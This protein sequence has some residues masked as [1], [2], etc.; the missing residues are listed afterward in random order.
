MKLIDALFA[1]IAPRA[2]EKNIVTYGEYRITVLTD[3]LFR[4]EYGSASF[5]DEATQAVWFRDLPPVGFSVSREGEALHIVTAACTLCVRP[6]PQDCTVLLDGCE[7]ALD[8]AGNLLGTTR[9]LDMNRKGKVLVNGRRV[10]FSD[11]A[12]LEAGVV[13][14]TGVA[15]LDD[16]STPLLGADGLTHPR[17]AVGIDRYIFAYGHDYRAAVRALFALC[18]PAP[19]LPRYAFGNW[20][21]RYHAYTD[22]EYLQ[23]TD[24]FER[25]RV[26]LSVATV[27]MD[28]HY[29]DIGAEFGKEAEVPARSYGNRVSGW[30]GF[31]WNR[32]LFPDHRAFLRELHARGLRVT[33]NLHPAD[34]VRWFED[35][36]RPM[37]AATG[38]DPQSRAPVAFD[39]SDPAFINAYFGVLLQGLQEDGVDFWWIDWQQEKVRRG[40]NG[41]FDPLWT[42]NHYHYLYSARGG[43]R[44]MTLSRYAGIGSHRYPL[45]FSG[46]TVVTWELLEF[47]PYFTATAA[48]AGYF[49]WSHDIGG[50]HFGIKDDELY[51]RWLQFAVYNPVLR[52]HSS[53]MALTGKEP[54]KFS[55]GTAAIAE[56]LLRRREALVPYLYTL[57]ARAHFLGRA[58]AEPMYYEYPASPQA[59][60]A[61]GQY[62]FGELMVAPVTQRTDAQTGLAK[63]RV[64]LPEGEWLD[65]STRLIYRGGRTVTLWRYL[66]ETPVFMRRGSLFVAGDGQGLAMTAFGE[67]G[68]F[69]LYED[70]GETR[71]FEQGVYNITQFTLR[72]EGEETVLYILPGEHPELLPAT[73]SL[74]LTFEGIASADVAAE[75]EGKKLS[76]RLT[77]GE[78]TEVFVPAYDPAAVVCVRLKNLVPVTRRRA[79]ERRTEQLFTRLNGDNGQI[80]AWYRAV[81]QDPPRQKSRLF[82]LGLPAALAEALWE[83]R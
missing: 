62:W 68:T 70:D 50:H 17:G 33:L 15:V 55:P 78:R 14:Q 38:V 77:G 47:M 36:Y 73:R 44:G 57:A 53:N 27:D 42:L 45:G 18:G 56:S 81:T 74:R 82:A 64:W 41:D 1:D 13:S 31:S 58:M 28:W 63:K 61:R 80:A 4:M 21:S 60:R 43:K 37:C 5:T 3:R 39:L 76:V 22:R 83:L 46:D 72:R 40:K 16:S 65:L 30:T 67:E 79:A 75:Q 59:Y 20:W 26:P 66:E 35:A 6:S 9:T 49:F 69:S 2:A 48:N 8:N 71:A 7:R 12:L 32:H 54:W 11:P 52:L 24:R 34:G 19:M 51:V 10:H 23:L 29:V 25:E